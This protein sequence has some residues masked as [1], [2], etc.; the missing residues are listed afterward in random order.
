MRCRTK[1]WDGEIVLT[2]IRGLPGLHNALDLGSIHARV[3]NKV[4]R[5]CECQFRRQWFEK[6]FRYTSACVVGLSAAQTTHLKLVLRTNGCITYWA[7]IPK[8]AARTAPNILCWSSGHA[9]T[10]RVERTEAVIAAKYFST[11]LASET[12]VFVVRHFLFIVRVVL[13]GGAGWGLWRLTAQP[14]RLS[15]LL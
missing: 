14:C 8:L 6:C 9:A 3:A 1:V 10:F 12:V 11:S 2:E 7:F 15:N 13:L 5:S 4:A